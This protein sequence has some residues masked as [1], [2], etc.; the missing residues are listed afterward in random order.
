MVS[1]GFFFLKISALLDIGNGE[2]ERDKKSF[3]FQEG[4]RWV[5]MCWGSV[6]LGKA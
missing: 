4:E 6:I 5:N 1:C 3:C 2:G